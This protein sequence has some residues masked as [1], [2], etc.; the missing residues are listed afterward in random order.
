MGAEVTAFGVQFSQLLIALVGGKHMPTNHYPVPA[1]KLS[2]AE[3]FTTF[4]LFKQ[5]TGES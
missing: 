5:K 1:K 2:Y 3:S 4:A